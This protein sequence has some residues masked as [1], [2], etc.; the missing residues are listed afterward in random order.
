MNREAKILEAV[1]TLVV[2]V[3]VAWMVV[4]VVT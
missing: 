1:C 4:T 3:F 2:W